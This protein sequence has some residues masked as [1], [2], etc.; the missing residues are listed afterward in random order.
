[1][2]K[3]ISLLLLSAFIQHTSAQIAATTNDFKVTWGAEYEFPKKHSDMGFWKGSNGYIN[4]SIQSGKSLIIQR[5]DK[6]MKYAG[7]ETISLES[8]PRNFVNEGI[9]NLG[10][11]FYWFYSVWDKPKEKEQ[12]FAQ[13]LD[14]NA[15]KLTGQARKI[16]ETNKVTG[17][18]VNKGWYN[19]QMANKYQFSRSRNHEMLVV[20]YR[21]P[22]M[23][24]DDSKNYDRMGWQVFNSSLDKV[25]GKDPLK[26]PYT[27]EMMDFEDYV[28]DSRGTVFLLAS[29]RE[30]NWK[31][32]KKDK[33]G[34]NHFEVLRLD[35]KSGEFTK[36]VLRPGARWVNQVLLTEDGKGDLLCTGFY[37]NSERSSGSNG[38]FVMKIEKDANAVKEVQKGFYEFP[39][40][41]LKQ[42][43]SERTKKK[44]EKKD[45]KEKEDNE[46]GGLTATNL[47]MRD[48]ELGDDG[49]VVL[50]A[51]EYYTITTTH[52]SPNGGT[53]TTTTYYYN[54]IIAM[55]IKADGELA[56]VH[57]IPKRQRGSRG[58]G[59][60]SFVM[61]TMNDAHYYFYLDNLKNLNLAM[62]RAPEEHVDGAGGFLMYTKIDENGKVSKGKIMDLREEEVRI[63][64]SDF[65]RVDEKQIVT[66][67]TV[68]KMSKILSLTLNERK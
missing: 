27:E 44:M 51:E 34:Y 42:F 50:S 62:D 57:K 3:L 2:K 25:W 64:G 40:E 23:D 53:T 67:A 24:K 19:I 31:E 8:F 22:P 14:V 4:V 49:S 37:S 6:K 63:Y 17:D 60:L 56:W 65:E 29:V 68:K 43:E 55:K 16:I 21:F 28:I 18:M 13:E 61:Y 46:D 33:K 45:R 36:I 58:R 5:F 54:D 59:G 52:S 12:L 10:D 20:S 1:M 15:G 38:V 11:K 48:V 47:K 66:R 30:T 35:E 7:E 41:M 32:L 26:M 39:V 9:M